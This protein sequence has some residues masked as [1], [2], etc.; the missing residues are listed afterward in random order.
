MLRSNITGY[1]RQT[2]FIILIFLLPISTSIRC[3]LNFR[4]SLKLGF[5]ASLRKVL[6]IDCYQ[7]NVFMAANVLH[8][9]FK[10]GVFHQLEKVLFKL[11]RCLCSPSCV[12]INKGL[13]PCTLL[14]LDYSVHFLKNQ[15]MFPC[16]L[17][18]LIVYHILFWLLRF[19]TNLFTL[20]TFISSTMKFNL[21]CML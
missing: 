4:P 14:K 15:L 21:L 20:L 12:Q 19:S 17:Q 16:L 5:I 3:S 6:F 11:V 1:Q 7:S 10:N 18:S 8:G 2:G 9:L 13:K